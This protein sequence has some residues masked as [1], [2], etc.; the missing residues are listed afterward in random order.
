M[1]SEDG[2][3]RSRFFYLIMNKVTSFMGKF[4][5]DEK[6]KTPFPEFQNNRFRPPLNINKIV[7]KNPANKE[8]NLEKIYILGSYINGNYSRKTEIYPYKL[9]N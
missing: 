7:Q 6:L 8:K 2:V 9:E 5:R 3:V 4:S 1:P